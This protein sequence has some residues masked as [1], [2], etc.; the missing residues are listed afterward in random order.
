MT[1]IILYY[2]TDNVE[3]YKHRIDKD[4]IIIIN[5]SINQHNE[6]ITYSGE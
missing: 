2:T 1:L 6:L 4:M 3:E 5:Y